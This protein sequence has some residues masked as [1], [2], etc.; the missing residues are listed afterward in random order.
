MLGG[1]NGSTKFSLFIDEN[2]LQY[3]AIGSSQLQL[4]GNTAG[5]SA[6]P[7]NI[8]AREH[9]NATFGPNK[10]GRKGES[11]SR[12]QKLHFSLNQGPYHDECE[13]ATCFPVQNPVSTGLRLSYDDDERNSSVTSASG[14]MTA[15]PPVILSLEENLLN[16]LNQQK[17][18]FDQYI[19]I[20][21]EN[22]VKGLKDITQRQ[23]A[24]FLAAIEKTVA[25]KLHDKDIEIENITGKNRE[26]I[27][28]IKQV[29]AD[30]QGW[31]H[32][33]KYNESLVNM[34]QSNLQQAISQGA[35]PMKEGFGESNIDDTAS[36]I[37]PTHS[38]CI[39]S[40]PVKKSSGN[41]SNMICRVCNMKEVSFLLMPC[42]HLCLCSN[43]EG[44]VFSCPVCRL[45][46]TAGVQVYLS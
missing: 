7:G 40:I 35:E 11:L 31:H 37:D 16:E 45:T 8:S 46:K 15:S 43:C 21:E 44:M 18:E 19:K 9:N 13:L 26:L 42:R 27:E 29:A 24:S 4:F 17:K 3:P 14:G 25:K 33:A 36:Y 2:R 1:E 28:R 39:P 41:D 23:M 34:L 30:T 32:R 5:Y 6:D 12:R 22:L 38:L 10:R 20:Q